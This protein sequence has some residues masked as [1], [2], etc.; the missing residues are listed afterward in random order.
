VMGRWIVFTLLTLVVK[1]DVYDISIRIYRDTN[2]FEPAGERLFT[3]SNC[4]ANFFS[5]I[6][7]SFMLSIVS[8]KAPQQ[9]VME[10]FDDHCNLPA[11]LEPVRA[12]YTDQCEPFFGEYYGVYKI[13]TRS[14][15]AGV[16]DCNSIVPAEQTFYTSLDCSGPEY[17]IFGYPTSKM[18]LN[19]QQTFGSVT[20]IGMPGF[21]DVSGLGMEDG[22]EVESDEGFSFEGAESIPLTFPVPTRMQL[23]HCL[24]YYMGTNFFYRMPD[25][26]QVHEFMFPNSPDCT[27]T[28]DEGYVWYAYTV[29][30]CYPMHSGMSFRWVTTRGSSESGLTSSVIGLLIAILVYQQN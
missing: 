10:Q 19:L 14:D 6:S 7:S 17:E 22:E 27:P 21:I 2:C 9:L 4:Y 3:T 11:D 18:P 1:A 26:S 29:N 30:F 20:T 12:M 15:C 25:A 16:R 5:N 24:T 8:L 23:D 13:Q 28:L